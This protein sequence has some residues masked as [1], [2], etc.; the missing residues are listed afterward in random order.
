MGTL[1][2]APRASYWGARQRVTRR[3]LEKLEKT[4]PAFMP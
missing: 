3:E 2:A 4:L 1:R